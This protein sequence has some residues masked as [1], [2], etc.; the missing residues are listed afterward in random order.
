M[1]TTAGAFAVLALSGKP[2][3]YSIAADALASS[4]AH[5]ADSLAQN[6]ASFPESLRAPAKSV[7]ELDRTRLLISFAQPVEPKEMELLFKPSDFA[8]EEPH[9]KAIDSPG[10]PWETVTHSSRRFWLRTSDG[11]DYTEKSVHSLIMSLPSSVNWVGGVYRLPG[12]KTRRGLF[13]PKPYVLIIKTAPQADDKA[14]TEFLDQLNLKEIPDKSQIGN[15]YR[16]F[17]LEDTSR[18]TVYA[19]PLLLRKTCKHLIS[20]THFENLHLLSGAVHVPTDQ[21]YPANGTYKG[22]WNFKGANGGI[23]AEAAWDILAPQIGQSVQNPVAVAVIDV[24]CDLDHPDLLQR[25]TSGY[26]VPD[27]L[28]GLPPFPHLRPGECEGGTQSHGTKCAG[29]IAATMDNALTPI[30]VAGLGA[31]S[32]VIM[33][34]FFFEET[35]FAFKQS[36]LHAADHGA[37]VISFSYAKSEWL[38]DPVVTDLVNQGIRYALD[39][40]LIV[41]VATGNENS[42]VSFPATH[43]GVIACGASNHGDVRWNTGGTFGSN[44]STYAQLCDGWCGVSVVAPGIDIPTTTTR[45]TSSLIVGGIA[46]PDYVDNFSGT[47]AAAPHVAGLAALLKTKYPA[48]GGR[49]IRNVIER[50]ADKIHARTSVN[51]G[52]YDYQE[53]LSVDP[54]T[55]RAF[56]NGTWCEPVGYGRINVHHAMDFADIVIKDWPEDDGTEPSIRREDEFFFTARWYLSDIVVRPAD[57][58]LFDPLDFEAS[59]VIRKGVVN[60]L[61][62]RITNMGPA[63]ARNVNVLCSIGVNIGPDFVFPGDWTTA[64]LL[65]K[66]PKLI[67]G[68]YS[69]AI[70][71]GQTTIAKFRLDKAEVDQIGKAYQEYSKDGSIYAI[72]AIAW[73]FAANDYAFNKANQVGANLIARRN[74]MAQRYL[75]VE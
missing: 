57:D 32:C 44:F 26:T 17:V 38:L 37:R 14:L 41:C 75:I 12:T 23:S 63:S 48:L 47:S 49:E 50:T 54:G 5:V 4:Q 16:Y 39:K 19:Y 6:V 13:C 51:P 64:P 71:P 46:R 33:P 3:R 1:K 43:P 11:Q 52:G 10:S 73:T 9:G 34:V 30:G 18:Q 72:S 29:V 60:Y 8:L 28:T 55:G 66:L 58:G 35:G 36:L 27:E 20:E 53:K 56:T 25:Y 40:G 62:V 65:W 61:Y 74:N 31:N 7:S 15:G 22:Q 67:P 59:S 45:G 70:A 2:D 42:Q 69:S 68:S 21:L 24:G